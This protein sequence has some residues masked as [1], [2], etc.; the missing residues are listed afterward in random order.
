[1]KF[2]PPGFQNQALVDKIKMDGPNQIQMK[3]THPLYI[4]FEVL[5]VH[6]IMIC[7]MQPLDLFLLLFYVRFYI[8]RYYFSLIFTTSYNII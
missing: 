1:M 8:S 5:K 6:L 3:N 4:V 2:F 7:E